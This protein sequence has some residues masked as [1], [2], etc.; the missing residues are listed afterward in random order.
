MATHTRSNSDTTIL[1]GIQRVTGNVSATIASAIS[2]A[3]P[4]GAS[5]AALQNTANAALAAIKLAVE[6]LDT[7]LAN[8][9]PV[10]GTVAISG[11]VAATQSGSW[12]V[13]T[14][15]WPATVDTNSGNKSA[16]T[17]RVVIA[18]D[19]PELPAAIVAPTSQ[20]IGQI[21]VT[22]SATQLLSTPLTGRKTLVVKN[23]DTAA[24]VYI[25]TSNS[26]SSTTGQKIG[27]GETW[28]RP[29]G[30]TAT[31]LIS[32]TGT[33]RIGYEEYNQ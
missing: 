30:S 4:S 17:P 24:S 29:W 33:V 1:P 10:S 22:A 16:S 6:S 8:P 3:L 20:L 19:Q 25:N 14:P 28:I 27:P 18:T 32:S 13:V 9:L 26:V 23:F 7:K 12:S 21:D 5:T 2:V 15:S 31:W 11:T